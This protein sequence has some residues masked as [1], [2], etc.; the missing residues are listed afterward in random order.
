[1]KKLTRKVTAFLMIVVLIILQL[2]TLVVVADDNADTGEGDI[3]R[4]KDGKGFY[5]SSEYMYKV[6]VYVGLSDSAD[7]S[8][9]LYI[10]WQMI[11]D[12]PIYIKPAS[13]TLPVNVIG[14][15]KNKVD[16]VK[17]DFLSP[18]II[19]SYM[20]CNPPPIPITN[21]GNIEAVKSYFGDTATL[22]A[23]VV[24]FANQRG[25][26]RENLIS[27]IPFTIGGATKKRP[28]SEIL[29]TKIGGVF[30]NQVP[31]LI[32]Y[33]PVI[34]SYLKDRTTILAFTATE[35]ALAQKMGFFNFKAG[36]SGQ[37]IGAMTH[38]D[39]PNSI[40]LEES[41][42]GFPVTSALVDGVYWSESRII[43]GGGWGMRMLR[44]NGSNAVTNNTTHDHEYRV[45][46][47]VITSVRIFADEDITPDNR[48]KSESSYRNPRKNTATVTMSANGY[49]KSTEIVVPKGGSQLVYLKWRTPSTPQD[50]EIEVEVTGNNAA[51]IDGTYRNKIVIGRV[52]DLS[53][54]TPPNPTANDRNNSFRLP[55]IPLRTDK[56][57]ANWGKFDANWRANWKWHANWQWI[58][59]WQLVTHYGWIGTGEDSYWGITGYRW[60]DRGRWVDNGRWVDEGSWEFSYTSYTATLIANKN[61]VPG[62]KTPTAKNDTMKSGYGVNIYIS[63]RVNTNAPSS[64]VTSAQNAISYFPEFNYKNYWRL[65][66]MTRFG[67]FEFKH[68]KYSTFNSRSHFTP[69]WFPDA[70]YT[71]F[72][73][74][75][76]VWTPAGMLRTNLHDHVNIEGNLFE[77]WH[78]APKGV[79][80]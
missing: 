40:I 47:N 2:A 58:S 19:T 62:S 39:L 43:A 26:T 78:I 53:F 31:W 51:R 44:V 35:Y 45:D 10:D 75:I 37:Y 28:A 71:V 65:L 11:G 74:I 12:V 69:L 59:N 1:M 30:Q 33:E 23:L 60:V 77:D 4:A 32:I 29:P 68:N 55:N 64:S 9:N 38:S 79:N 17:G 76:D 15:S 54:N 7:S 27:N 49:T 6:S 57:T 48:H 16:Y 42:F 13:F 25:T 34:I 41:W 5:R 20:L 36:S 73:E 70:K 8:S 18:M 22:N 14:S 52:V 24:A 56:T 72:T 21:Y 61:L 66:D 63:S 50:V 46:T 80:D 67:D 3:H